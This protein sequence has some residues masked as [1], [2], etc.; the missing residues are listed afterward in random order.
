MAALDDDTT[1]ATP[2]R[3]WELETTAAAVRDRRLKSAHTAEGAALRRRLAACGDAGARLLRR[4]LAAEPDAKALPNDYAFDENLSVR[5]A[6]RVAD[7]NCLGA[8]VWECGAVLADWLE[9]RPDVVAGER[10]LELGAGLGLVGKVAARGAASVLLT[11]AWGAPDAPGWAALDWND[12]AAVAAVRENF[13]GGAPDVVVAADVVYS[14]G[15]A[16]L[17]A[18]L[19]SLGAGRAYVAY[20]HRRARDAAAWRDLERDFAIVEE[21]DPLLDVVRDCCRVAIL[22]LEPRR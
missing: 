8:Q 6:S 2:L 22:R 16:G 4:L 15:A 1:E 13:A 18:A 19:R 10:V 5:Q 7:G 11:D 14:D 9:R 3:I 21:S 20:K 12:A 17:P